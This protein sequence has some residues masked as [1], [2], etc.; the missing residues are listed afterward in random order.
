MPIRTRVTLEPVDGF[1]VLVG[2]VAG[3][4]GGA[5]AELDDDAAVTATLPTLRPFLGQG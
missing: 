4:A 2:Q 3:E 5:L 1:P